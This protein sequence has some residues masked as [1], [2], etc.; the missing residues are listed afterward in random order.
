MK[1]LRLFFVLAVIVT[2][3]TLNVSVA[4]KST[5]TP[6]LQYKDMEA[7]AEESSATKTYTCFKTFS[8][9]IGF[10]RQCPSCVI[11]PLSFGS[12]SS[13]CTK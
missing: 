10:P 7:L 9:G 1:K 4:L 3:L 11:M 8:G 6:T 12:D 5:K 2:A 13:K